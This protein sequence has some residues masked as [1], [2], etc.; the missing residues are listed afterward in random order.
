MKLKGGITNDLSKLKHK[1][2]FKMSCTV[3]QFVGVGQLCSV[4]LGL[5]RRGEPYRRRCPDWTSVLLWKRPDGMISLAGSV[6]WKASGNHLVCRRALDEIQ[7]GSLLPCMSSKLCVEHIISILIYIITHGAV[8]F[9]LRLYAVA[10]WRS[11]LDLEAIRR[12]AFPPFCFS[13]LFRCRI[14]RRW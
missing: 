3:G 12:S 6:Q 7:K 14:R 13:D 8:I 2:C 4:S 10:R 5:S 11:W 1:L 9:W